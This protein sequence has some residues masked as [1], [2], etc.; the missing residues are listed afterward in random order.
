MLARVHVV[1]L[2]D[3]ISSEH[4]TKVQDSPIRVPPLFKV[5]VGGR[6]CVRSMRC[7][8]C[9][10]SDQRSRFVL[11]TQCAQMCVCFDDGSI[12]ETFFSL[13]VDV[14]AFFGLGDMLDRL[15]SRIGHDGL[16]VR[17]WLGPSIL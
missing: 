16:H 1:R 6:S 17:M 7:T 4:K 8:S 9:L 5:N 3:L 13:G 2:V 12:D 15:V 11:D 10:V 14:F